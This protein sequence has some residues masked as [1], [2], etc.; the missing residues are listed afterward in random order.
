MVA[1]WLGFSMPKVMA[2]FTTN[3]WAGQNGG[4]SYWTNSLNWSPNG[5]PDNNSVITIN[6]GAVYLTSDTQ[7]A[8]VD[9]NG[10]TIG[11]SSQGGLHSLTVSDFFNLNGAN[12]N[13]YGLNLNELINDGQMRWEGSGSYAV[14]SSAF[15][16]NNGTFTVSAGVTDTVTGNGQGGGTIIN[17]VGA[18]FNKTG[19]GQLFFNGSG[20][21]VGLVN[22]G[23]V[24]LLG[25]SI[26]ANVMVTN[27]GIIRQYGGTVNTFNAGGLFVDTGGIY[28]VQS[29]AVLA[30][31]LNFQGGRL[32]GN[33]TISPYGPLI[34]GGNAILDAGD[35]LGEAGRLT[36][37][38]ALYLNAGGIFHAD[39]GGTTPGLSYDQTLVAGFPQLN[40]GTLEISLI[41]GFAPATNDTFTILLVSDS[42]FLSGSFTNVSNGERLTTTDGSGSF[43][44]SINNGSVVLSD[45]VSV[46]EPQSLALCAI[47]LS[48]WLLV[49]RRQ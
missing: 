6:N 36:V 34:I 28:D 40:G 9:W 42:S 18:T 24:N 16:Q 37:A 26:V 2:Q 38:T 39:I 31:N 17:N 12:N 48:G 14:N 25:G 21:G 20:N 32:M 5:V 27:S 4:Y 11:D 19:D 45:Y 33:G 41:N 43:V 46:P 7:I 10:G 30:G 35:N 44:V 29:N 22:A 47:A 3:T 1:F 23:T 13:Q 15:I 49:K 8:G